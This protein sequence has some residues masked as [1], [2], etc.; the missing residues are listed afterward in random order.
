MNHEFQRTSKVVRFVLAAAAIVAST[1][2]LTWIEGLAR[3]EA[4]GAL[5]SSN[6]A[7]ARVT[8]M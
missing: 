2:V 8:Q 3:H 7:H 6:M 1:L 4:G 5:A